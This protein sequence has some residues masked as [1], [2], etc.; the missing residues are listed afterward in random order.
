MAELSY[1]ERKKLPAKDFVFPKTRSYPIEDEG[2]ARAALQAAGGARSGKP[3]PPAKRAKIEA[4]VHRKYPEIGKKR[5]TVPLSS[6][7]RAK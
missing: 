3:A 7:K 1:K 5:E 6:L 4:A 2:H